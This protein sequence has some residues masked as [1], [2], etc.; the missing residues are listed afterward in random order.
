M[1]LFARHGYDPVSPEA[2]AAPR[3]GDAW[4]RRKVAWCLGDASILTSERREIEARLTS[5][6]REALGVG[7]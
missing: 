3:S 2:T 1:K 7:L 6:L 5:A 4:V